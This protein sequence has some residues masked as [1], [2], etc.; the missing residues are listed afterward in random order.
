[1]NSD[2]TPPTQNLETDHTNQSTQPSQLDIQQLA[3]ILLETLYKKP[4]SGLGHKL[5]VMSLIKEALQEFKNNDQINYSQADLE[6]AFIYLAKSGY[7]RAN[8][9]TSDIASITPKGQVYIQNYLAN[10]AK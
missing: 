6:Q 8:G 1:M 2:K 3:D 10:R 4:N 9:K 5:T 7:I